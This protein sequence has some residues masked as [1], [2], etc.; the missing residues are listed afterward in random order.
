MVRGLTN[1][2]LAPADAEMIIEGHF[3]ELGYVEQEGPYGEFYGF[4]GPVHMDPVFHVTAITHRADMLHQTVRHSGQNLSWTESGNLGGL[5][6]ELAMTRLLRAAGI[7]PAAVSSAP[8]AN[9]RQ[10][11][12]VALK[13]GHAGQARLA[14]S[15]LMSIPRLKHIYVVDD[16]I[17]VFSEEQM[18]WAMSTRFRSDRDLVIAT[19]FPPFYMDPTVHDYGNVA[20]LGF[21]LTAP[22]GVPESIQ[23]RR[24]FATRLPAPRAPK[25]DSVRE[26][27]AVGPL[28]FSEIMTAMGS[29]DGREVALELDVLREEGVLMRTNDGQ[30]A[31]D[32]VLAKGS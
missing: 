16:D 30:W 5:N 27:L 7:E 10:H 15:A 32:S 31:L 6:A 14:I 9:G 13:R 1:G 12:R 2:V 29:E 26:A 3:D 17:D 28:Y 4:Y 20:K 19:N 22:Y 24:A 25:Q 18:E 23:T 11:A 8:A 21:D